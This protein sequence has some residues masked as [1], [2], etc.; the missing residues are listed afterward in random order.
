MKYGIWK[1]AAPEYEKVRVLQDA[2]YSVLTA[3]VLCG[4]GF[5][6]P[7]KAAQLLKCDAP[8]IDPFEMKEMDKAVQTIRRGLE[9]HTRI[10]VFGDYDVD[11]ITATCLLTDYLRSV[12]ADCV[13]HIPGRLEEGYGLNNG[14]IDQL[15][16]E[17]VRMIIT[18]DCGITALEEAEKCAQMGITLIVTDH[19]ECKE[20]LPCAAAV[21]DPHRADRTYPH[22]NLCGVG[23]AFKLA[24]ALHGDQKQIAA[25]YADLFC[26][27]TIADVM[28]LCGENRRLVVQGLSALQK[29]KRL[30]VR[31]L[32]AACGCDTQ[33]V[34]ASTIG[35]VLAP[36]VNAAGRMEHAELA[37]QLFLTEDPA[38]AEELAETLCRLNRERQA[39]ESEI[40]RE[41]VSRLRGRKASESAI[42][43]AGENWHQGVVGIV[44]SRLS[45]EYCR[46]TFLICLNGDRGKASSR[47]YG[48]FNLFS[49]LSEM[50]DLLEGYGGH[51]L[52]A[53]FTIL[54]RNIDEFRRRICRCS[55]EFNASGLAKSALEIDCE[56][57]SDLLTEENAEGLAQ[58]EPCGTGCPKP[59]FCL[60]ELTVERVSTVGGGKHLRLRLRAQGG[61]SLQAIYFSAGNL[62]KKLE[63][64][65]RVDA[66]FHLQVNEYHG[67]KTIQLNL[68]DLRRTSP[69]SLF[70]RFAAGEALSRIE[71]AAIA[72]A[73]RDV[74]DVWQYLTA[75]APSGWPVRSELSA[76]GA[77]IAEWTDNR[78]SPRRTLSCLAI[79]QEL[80][81]LRFERERAVIEICLTPENGPN[82][83]DNSTLYHALRGD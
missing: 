32:M 4:R 1:I 24:A 35:Y 80:G 54:R 6:T 14:A 5:D 13:A 22:T 75:H 53:G 46:P 17:G 71:R 57:T 73:R 37:V 39:T 72:P 55:E 10:A 12:G 63:V 36:R 52:A 82:P 7:E 33:E 2:G 25:R 21:I 20:A 69:N 27:G 42:V 49:S 3:N 43:L 60:S 31:A 11:G 81:L 28:P 77:S 18:V 16:A 67:A 41:A 66:A 62:S 74:A 30:G 68:I 34:T 76:L 65:E 9:Q 44:A 45:E 26:L 15:Y 58:L 61:A 23:V 83:L 78:H 38:E 56:I 8:L 19:H 51:E 29:P 59:V 70:D 79:L 47:S 48:G 40:Y 50:S 64:G